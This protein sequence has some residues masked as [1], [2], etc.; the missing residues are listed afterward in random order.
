MARL[1]K[2]L[3]PENA[4]FAEGHTDRMVNLA[5]GGQNGFLPDPKSYV[6]NA[7][8]VQ[9]NLIAI[10][11]EAPRG[12]KD[13]PNPEVWTATLK[14]LVELHAQSIE[15]LTSTLTVEYVE[16]AIG[17]AGEMQEDISNVTRA[18]SVPVFN[19][20]EK[21]GM[22]INTF[23]NGW[24]VNL[25]GD[26]ETKVPRVMNITKDTPDSAPIDLLPDY[27]GMSVL[28]IEPNPTH[29]K[30][31]SAWLSTNMMPK[32][33]GECTG[34]RDLTAG[35]EQL[36]HSI[37]FTAITQV[38]AGVDAI[39]Q[40]FLDR[41]NLTGVNPN[42]IPAFVSALTADVSD[43]GNGFAHLAEEAAAGLGG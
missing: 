7:A 41:M 19:W 33:S 24:I 8:Y 3:L 14:N 32:S 36:S 27:T 10:L 2:T 40:A 29:T 26:P 13:L 38:G 1:T 20:P 28:F 11:L 6:S 21:Y 15:G 16:N 42:N 18:R 9:R 22:A 31:V 35:G 17:G 39:G 30:V 5:V 12:F 4:A 34:K 37:E 25:I 43:T 23:L